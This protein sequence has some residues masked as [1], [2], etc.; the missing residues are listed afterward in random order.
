MKKHETIE[1]KKCRRLEMEEKK[2][3]QAEEEKKVEG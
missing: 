3:K 1:E 2:E